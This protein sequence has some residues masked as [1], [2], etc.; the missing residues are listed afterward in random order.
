MKIIGKTYYKKNDRS[1]QLTVDSINNNIITFT[2]GARC[3]TQTLMNDFEEINPDDFLNQDKQYES[4]AKE[5]LHVSN[6]NQMPIMEQQPVIMAPQQ[7][8]NNG[9]PIYNPTVYQAPI[10]NI[11]TEN[12]TPI[13]TNNS[14]GQQIVYQQAD[15]TEEAFFKKMKKQI[16]HTFDISIEELLPKREQLN[17]VNDMFEVSASDFFAK[18]IVEKMFLDKANLILKVR[19]QIETYINGEPIKTK[20]KNDNKRSTN[21]S[22]NNNKE[23]TSDIVTDNRGEE[24]LPKSTD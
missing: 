22:Y 9:Q 20:K 2:N 16:A 6:V 15:T 1:I 4:L 19:E 11:P 17:M 13:I 10:E 24:T 21:T 3:K 5:T 7:M 14:A 18:A 8:L 12:N 23:E